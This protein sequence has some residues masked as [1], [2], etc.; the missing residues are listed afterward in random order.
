M[1]SIRR[2]I[3]PADIEDAIDA[4]QEGSEDV[5]LPSSLVEGGPLGI[6]A[7]LIQMIATWSQQS[8]DR[9]LLSYS[10]DKVEAAFSHLADHP[11]GMAAIF[12][13]PHIQNSDGEMVD[14]IRALKL[15]ASRV[16]AMQEARLRETQKGHGVFLCCFSGSRSE[17]LLPLYSA[18]NELRSSDDFESLTD[19]I[20]D[21]IGANQARK[22]ISAIASLIY[23]LFENTHDHARE[24]NQ[25]RSFSWTHPGIRG[26]LAKRVS[27]SALTSGGR[28]LRGSKA[29]T[30]TYLHSMPIDERA[31]TAFLELAVFDNGPGIAKKLHTAGIHPFPAH[32]EDEERLIRTA[33]EVGETSKRS[34]RTGYGL[35]EIL[36]CL[37]TLRGTMQLR[38]GRLSLTQIFDQSTKSFNPDHT[39]SRKLLAPASGTTYVIHIPLG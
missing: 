17:Y 37:A 28:Q 1:L 39:F 6:E 10:H 36:R 31:K 26:I 4:V 29:A 3:S 18:P 25:G 11:F 38:T 2:A 20:I 16:Q 8:K 32:I 22:H 12:L 21:I 15:I 34:G 35:P 24:D 14:R 27:V 23:E 9:S 5:K 7:F 33:F 19:A 13:A 30:L